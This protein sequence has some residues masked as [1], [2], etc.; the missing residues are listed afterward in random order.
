[1]KSTIVLGAILF[2]GAPFG[3][4][5]AAEIVV[6]ESSAARYP[7]G[8][9]LDAAAPIALAAGESLTV[10]TEDARLIKIDGPHNGPA[11]G[12]AP[13]PSAVRRALA[14][15]IVEEPPAVGGVGGV[16][17]GEGEEQAADTRPDP[18]L[19]HAGR[20][21]DQC[22]LCGESVGVW[23]DSAD[24]AVTAELGFLLAESSVE[25]RWDAGQQRAAWP[26]QVELRDGAVYLLRAKAS[27]LSVPIQLHVL[28]P[29]LAGRGLPAA[30]W[31]AAKGCTAQARLMLRES[32]GLP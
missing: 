28:A 26:A 22:V 12:P 20:S 21:G 9:I 25:I 11:T 6:I 1:M 14:Q 5:E 30:A 32:P 15:L 29:A 4:A 16:R 17:A 19:L 31:L 8:Q 23:R 13:D 2:V 10:V 24:D 18:W 7:A 3:V 27:L